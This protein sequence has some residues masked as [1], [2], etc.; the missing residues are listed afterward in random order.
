MCSFV[1]SGRPSIHTQYPIY[2]S[3]ISVLCKKQHVS[4]YVCMWSD[5][6]YIYIWPVKWVYCIHGMWNW[7]QH[8]M[9]WNRTNDFILYTIVIIT[10]HILY[11]FHSIVWNANEMLWHIPYIVAL[12][13][14]AS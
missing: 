13:G 9:E 1:A 3:G 4:I 12:V 2:A 7:I 5:Y 10:N 8:G 14:T 11:V 6:A